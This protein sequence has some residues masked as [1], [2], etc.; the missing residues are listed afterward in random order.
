MAVLE[1]KIIEINKEKCNGCG[2]CVDACHEGAIRMVDGKAELVSD[3]YCDGL[4][5]C[6]GPCP[7]GALS[8]VTRAA[9]EFDPDAVAKRMEEMKDA[10]GPL[11]CGCPGSMA[12]ELKR[13]AP[14]K[15]K[16]NEPCG[17]PGSGA[18]ELKLE[19]VAPDGTLGCGCPGS[20]SR[21]L[22]EVESCSCG[23]GCD[24]EAPAAESEL[25]N[26]P[27]QLKLVPPSAPYLKGADI[28]LAADCA[29][30]AVPDFHARYLRNKPVVIACPKLEDNDPQ[31]AKLA[32]IVKTARPASLTVL[33]MEVP[34]CGG[35]VRVA[36]EA[37][38][39]SG[40]DV[41]VKT[42]IVGTDGSEK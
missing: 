4:G 5:D 29:A 38:K 42:I 19:P 22:K 16:E 24:E 6:L 2:L 21:S 7:T 9:G 13:P 20:M 36:E 15:A 35:L 32:E 8:I 12:R 14:A 31:V 11:P 41:P 33:R 30:V 23:C 18:V 1:R 34:C 26:W 17:C 40:I 27:V 10:A 39:L 25:M 37:V 28:L 3:I